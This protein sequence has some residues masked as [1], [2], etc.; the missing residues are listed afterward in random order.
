MKTE[1]GG[2]CRFYHLELEIKNGNN[3]GMKLHEDD[4]HAECR[5][6]PPVMGLNED[7]R[8]MVDAEVLSDFYTFPIVRNLGWCGEWQRRTNVVPQT[9]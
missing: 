1:R 5:R 7:F 8:A 3:D 2:L 4:F 6:Y 9:S